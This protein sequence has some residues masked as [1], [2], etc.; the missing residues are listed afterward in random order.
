MNRTAMREA[1]VFE[2]LDFVRSLAR[3]VLQVENNDW[4]LCKALSRL[5]HVNHPYQRKY[6]PRKLTTDELL[7]AEALRQNGITPGSAYRWFLVARAPED[8][9]DLV[10]SG[11]LTQNE[12]L[13]S[14]VKQREVLNQGMGL[15]ILQDIRRIMEV[16]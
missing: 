6:G 11:Q 14:S 15:E 5:A 13:K 10:K 8:I 9:R 12:A 3:Q 1:P 16:M 4:F 2:K 7:L